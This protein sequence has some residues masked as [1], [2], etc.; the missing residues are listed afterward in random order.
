MIEAA[1]AWRDSIVSL[2]KVNTRPSESDVRFDAIVAGL[3]KPETDVRLAVV[4]DEHPRLVL[5]GDLLAG[6]EDRRDDPLA[7]IVVGDLGQVRP[8]SAAASAVLV[9]YAAACAD[10]AEKQPAPGLRVAGF[11]E[12]RI[13]RGESAAGGLFS[14]GAGRSPA[15]R[16]VRAASRRSSGLSSA[17]NPSNTSR[18]RSRAAAR[19][20]IASARTASDCAISRAADSN[21][22]KRSMLLC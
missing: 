15:R 5:R 13:P 6:L 12:Q 17:A 16:K 9:T 10:R 4:G 11:I 22:T 18:E 19:P 7:G 8:Q 3:G 1:L 2:G 20:A 21:N 14:T